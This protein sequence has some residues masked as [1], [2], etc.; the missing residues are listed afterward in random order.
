MK[1]PHLMFALVV[2]WITLY[3]AEPPAAAVPVGPDGVRRSTVPVHAPLPPEPRGKPYK[4]PATNWET[5]PVLWGW[6][7]E[8]PDGSGLQ[9][10]GVNQLSDDGRGHTL[11]KEGG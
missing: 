10:G 7:C 8:L 2:L 4:V 6:A 3:A 5:A 9:L 11:V 1:T